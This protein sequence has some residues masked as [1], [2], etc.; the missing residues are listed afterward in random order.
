MGH[1]NLRRLVCTAAAAMAMAAAAGDRAGAQAQD[2]AKGASLMADARKAIGGQDKLAAVKRVQANG[3]FKRA[4]GNNTL[5][6]DFDISIE[7]PDKYRLHEETGTA[8]GPIAERTQILNGTEVVDQTSGSGFG[9]FGGGGRRG[10]GFGGG[11]GRDGGGFG[12]GGGGR[13]RFGDGA[14]NGQNP[15]DGAAGGQAQG[16]PQIDPERLRDAQRRQRQADLSRYL[17]AW[18]LSTDQPVAWIGTAQS[19]DG[20]ADVLQVSPQDGVP[21]RLFLDTSTHMPLMITW[22]GGGGGRFGFGG[23]GGRRGDGAAG[24]RGDGA[25]AGAPPA[26][27]PADGGG[28]QAARQ[29][30][31]GGP[32]QPVTNEL[33]LS[34]YKTVNGIKLPHSISRSINGQTIEEMTVKSYKINPNFKANTFTK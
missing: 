14:A 6:G 5:E 4:A 26:G 13:G 17:L 27:E 9:G 24:R 10:G 21:M 11:G 16:Q 32:Q 31:R 15:L 20:T 25:A 12:G 18:L 29:G 33:H 23:G 2:T 1:M 8:G 22:E 34:E 19:P 28:G 3:A 7:S 30:R